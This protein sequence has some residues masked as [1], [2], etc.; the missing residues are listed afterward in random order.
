MTENFFEL[1]LISKRLFI[2]RASL[3]L[4][5]L[6]TLGIF[7]EAKG[8]GEAGITYIQSLTDDKILFQV[9]SQ[10][11]SYGIGENIIVNYV[12]RNKGDR[13]VYIIVESKVYLPKIFTRWTL[14]TRP[15]ASG[16]PNEFID[17]RLIKISAG[18][19]LKGTL[20]VTNDQIPND[21]EYN[22]EVWDVR[23]GFSYV[24]DAMALTNC[25]DAYKLPCLSDIFRKS[26]NLSI[27]NL[28][29]RL[30]NH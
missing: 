21:L 22:D 19:A 24:F 7:V 25:S 8:Q 29:I 17:Y 3:F 28:P 23:V 11:P 14:E 16:H 9:S 10:K 5:I 4:A 30:T 26:R 18:K 13:P 12:I 15:P 27:G 1:T 2:L 20:T 6:L